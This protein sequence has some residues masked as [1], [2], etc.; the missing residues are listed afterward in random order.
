MKTIASVVEIPLT[1]IVPGDNDRTVFEPQALQALADSI[2]A[3]GLMQPITVRPL[4]SDVGT[5]FGKPDPGNV[6][7]QIVAGE[8]RFWAVNLLGWPTISAIVRELN[9]EQADALMLAENV[10]RA[11]LNP[12]DEA[13]AYHKRMSKH[14]WTIAQIAG[15]ANVS[16]HRV[17]ARLK[18]LDLV[19]EAQKLI[20]DR[21]MGVQFGEYQE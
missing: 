14:D 18:L 17:S 8:R 16:T 10:H 6:T 21:Q 15:K 7:Y 4:W 20:A 3:D 2:Q 11:D 13:R 12:M 9:D 19:P 1:Q 5:L